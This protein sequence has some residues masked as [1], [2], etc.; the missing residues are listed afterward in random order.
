MRIVH[1]IKTLEPQTGGV[2]SA[3]VDLTRALV[4]E[5]HHVTLLTHRVGSGALLLPTRGDTLTIDEG[6]TLSD[7]GI[8]APAT[9]RRWRTH[10]ARADVAH[11]HYVW[12]PGAYQVAR[13]ARRAGRPYVVSTHGMLSDWSMAQRRT[14]KTVYFH[15]ILGRLLRGSAGVVCTSESELA[16]VSRRVGLRTTVR[17]LPNLFDTS[18][19]ATAPDPSLARSTWPHLADD[20]LQLLFLG[21]LHRQKGVDKAVDMLAALTGQGHDAHLTVAGSWGAT[22]QEYRRAVEESIA[23]QGLSDLVHFVGF[24]S[25][26]A[27]ASLFAAADVFVLPTAL[28]SFGYVIYEAL[29]SGTPALV[30][31]GVDAWQELARTGCVLVATADGAAFARAVLE[32]GLD[33]RR[34]REVGEGGR[35][36]VLEQFGGTSAVDAHTALYSTAADLG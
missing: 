6:G 35:R 25:G 20:V 24:V 36:W 5:G 15:A 28:E 27:K 34:F 1:Y 8:A 9:V 30:S 13:L 23:R 2:V 29:A 19:Y 4:A 14:K 7:L 32:H 17:Y 33:R 11:L 18:P 26:E 22:Q 31:Y 16:Q 3:V 10:V 21:R 12:S